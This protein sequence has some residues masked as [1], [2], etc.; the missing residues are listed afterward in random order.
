VALIG[1]RPAGVD[2]AIFINFIEENSRFLP[3]IVPVFGAAASGKI[4]HVA[5]ALTLAAELRATTGAATPDALQL[6]TA[7]AT[8]C[9]SFLTND[10][11]LPSVPGLKVVKLA[12]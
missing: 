7:L 4:E 5:S 9:S 8:G 12:R 11:R 2:P 10:R 6:A 1:S 3:L